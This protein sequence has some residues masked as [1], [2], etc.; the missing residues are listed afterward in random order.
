[1]ELELDE[2]EVKDERRFTFPLAGL[3]PD[4]KTASSTRTGLSEIPVNRDDG[5]ALRLPAPVA[6]S[7]RLMA[8]I[9]SALVRGIVP[10]TR[11]RLAGDERLMEE[12]CEDED[13]DEDEEDVEEELDLFSDNTVGPFL[14]PTLCRRAD[15]RICS[16]RSGVRPVPITEQEI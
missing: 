12:D 9:S 13:D 1:M 3:T 11:A 8:A 15:L 16:I 4:R 6:L 14:L 7:L 10:L 5:L 2:D